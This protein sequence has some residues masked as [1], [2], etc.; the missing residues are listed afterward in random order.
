MVV[1]S[2]ISE[3]ISERDIDTSSSKDERLKDNKS[4][5]IIAGF[6]FIV[7]FYFFDF[8]RA[9][10]LGIFLKS[11][12]SIAMNIQVIGTKKCK[13]TQKGIRF[14]KERSM[15]YHFRDIQD[16]ELSPGEWTKIFQQIN[17]DNLLNA[18]HPLYKKKGLS[19]QIFDVKETLIENPLLLRT[20]ILRV[21]QKF[22][23][24]FDQKKWKEWL[25]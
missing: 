16:K 9:I 21:D 8:I 12:Y 13:E 1:W 4:K 10:I 18:D 11:N 7:V 22:Y 5:T 15:D 14:L 23:L 19:Y 20:P 24:G 17:C 2:K 3:S 25:N 6:L